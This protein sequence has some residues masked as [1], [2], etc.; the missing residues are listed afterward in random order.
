MKQVQ[1]KPGLA[2]SSFLW[3]RLRSVLLR[4]SVWRQ[5]PVSA[6]IAAS[7]GLWLKPFK[8]KSKTKLAAQKTVEINSFFDNSMA[9]VTQV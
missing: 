8:G 7:R 6:M 9:V 5:R 3:T 2:F 4:Y 1:E